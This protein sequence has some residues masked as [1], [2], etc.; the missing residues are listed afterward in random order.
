MRIEG[1]CDFCGKYGD[2]E[3]GMFND[4]GV[5]FQ[6]IVERPADWAAIFPWN[7][8]RMPEG[9]NWS[10]ESMKEYKVTS[11]FTCPDCCR[12]WWPRVGLLPRRALKVAGD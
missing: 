3:A 7:K 5:K 10:P 4:R 6:R 2:W 8:R 12:A 11:R 1:T 9:S